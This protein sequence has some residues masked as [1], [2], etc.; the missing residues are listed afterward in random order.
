MSVKILIYVL[1]I[2]LCVGLVT[3]VGFARESVEGTLKEVPAP[4]VP[5]PTPPLGEKLISIDNETLNDVI[6]LLSKEFNKSKSEIEVRRAREI[7]GG[8]LVRSNVGIF[9]VRNGT[10]YDTYLHLEPRINGT[11]TFEIL[12]EELLSREVITN[13]TKFHSAPRVGLHHE[14]SQYDYNYH[15]SHYSSRFYFLKRNFGIF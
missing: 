14:F 9:T 15:P 11:E 7:N 2:I 5:T 4:G 1:S 6:G 3:N 8:V 12:M 10:V 13:S